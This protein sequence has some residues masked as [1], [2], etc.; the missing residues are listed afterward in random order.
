MCVGEG[1]RL[2]GL[3]GQCCFLLVPL[4][5]SGRHLQRD[6]ESWSVETLASSQQSPPQVHLQ[7]EAVEWEVL[8][9]E[10]TVALGSALLSVQ[11]LVQGLLREALLLAE[12]F[13]V[14][15]QVVLALVQG[16]LVLVQVVLALM[17]GVRQ[18]W[19][20]GPGTGDRWLLDP[21]MLN[22]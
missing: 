8:H 17:E 10:L 6:L 4:A 15:V 7:L 19:S 13:L 2:L 21:C 18:Q 12:R 20:V 3:I 11:V 14:L 1:K 16:A 5:V 22:S 9:L